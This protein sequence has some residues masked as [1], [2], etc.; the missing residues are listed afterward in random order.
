MAKRAEP[1]RGRAGAWLLLVALALGSACAAQGPLRAG[2]AAERRA[3]YDRAVVEYTN[4]V[5]ANPDDR[6]ARASLERV[7]LRAA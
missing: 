3:D 1:V 6:T 5:R 2:Q 4:A 7:R